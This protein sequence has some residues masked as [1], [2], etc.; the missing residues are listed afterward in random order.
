MRRDAPA[1][2]RNRQPILEVLQRVLPKEGLVLELASGTGQHA[3]WYA[4]ALPHLRWQ[5][6]DRD[7]ETLASIAAWRDEAGLPNLLAPLLLDA[8][9]PQ[10]PVPRADALVAINLVHASPWEATLGLLSG[11]RRLLP[12]GGPVILYGAWREKGRTEPSNEAFDL[13][14]KRRDPAFG[15]KDTERVIEAAAGEGLAWVETVAMPANNRTLIFRK[16]GA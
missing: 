2:H 3:S 14:L 1:A 8:T 6:T 4:E 10:W 16:S 12:A 7:P 5:P 9:W 13:D 15:L 11:A